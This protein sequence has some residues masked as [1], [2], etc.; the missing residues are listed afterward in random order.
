MIAVLSPAKLM[1]EQRAGLPFPASVPVFTKESEALVTLLATM[2]AEQL[3]Q[4]MRISGRLARLNAQRY[5]GWAGL[6]KTPAALLYDGQV[7]RGLRA[8]DL[9]ADDLRFAQRHLRILSGLYGLLKPMDAIRP[10]RLEMGT[11]LETDP[12]PTSLYAYWGDRITRG[13]GKALRQT[14]GKVLV[15]LASSEYIRSVD[16]EA[17][18][19]RVVKPVFKDRTA[20]GHRVVA[21]HAKRQRGAM[22]RWIVR[23]R[24]LDPEGLKKYADDGYRFEAGESSAD[25]WIFLR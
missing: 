15:S 21:M 8:E 16:T 7:Y 14:Q 19:V 13:L 2:D 25:Q 4:L 9:D 22:A 3:G 5:K 17:L 12:G 18:K 6:R 23:H 24:M 1:N 20:R 10:H 11:R